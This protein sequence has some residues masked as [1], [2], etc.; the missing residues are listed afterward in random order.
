MT[1]ENQSTFSVQIRKSFHPRWWSGEFLSSFLFASAIAGSALSNIGIEF[2]SSL[3]ISVAALFA[4]FINFVSFA[5]ISGAHFNPAVT[6]AFALCGKLSIKTMLLYWLTQIIG[7]CSGIAFIAF[8]YSQVTATNP[9]FGSFQGTVGKLFPSFATD[10]L[11]IPIVFAGEIVLTFLFIFF[12][13]MLS[14]DENEES[15]LIDVE[16]SDTGDSTSR[17]S[18]S[19]SNT[20]TS[21]ASTVSTRNAKV[22]ANPKVLLSP[23]ILSSLIG[24]LVMI[25]K[26]ISGAFFNPALFLALCILTFN[27][28][29]FYV[30]LGAQLLGTFLALIFYWMAFSSKFSEYIPVNTSSNN[31][32]I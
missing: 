11:S 21:L 12:V 9:F 31:I 15:S 5:D 4:S 28:T 14:F 6:L 10:S 20:L 3:K 13:S 29:Y 25:G 17:S 26:P 7:F 22:I 2:S 1:I 8:S 23:F 32:R 24:L 18:S 16:L 27:F 19:A 30:Y